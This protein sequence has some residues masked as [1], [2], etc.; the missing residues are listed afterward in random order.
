MELSEKDLKVHAA[1]MAENAA[2]RFPSVRSLED[3][4]QGVQFGSERWEGEVQ[5]HVERIEEAGLLVK[6]RKDTPD[7][8][9]QH[10]DDKD[11]PVRLMGKPRM[12]VTEGEPVAHE[13]GA[14]DTA[15]T[16]DAVQV[17][18]DTGKGSE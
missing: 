8:P 9:P 1:L 13:V 16:D 10:R 14:G 11:K 15:A 4:M 5:S 2:G 17:D 18:D 12:P 7:Y 3:R 6:L